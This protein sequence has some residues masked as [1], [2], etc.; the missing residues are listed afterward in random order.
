MKRVRE[1]VQKITPESED[2]FTIQK[3]PD[4]CYAETSSLLGANAK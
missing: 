1:E 4:V 3:E 2:I